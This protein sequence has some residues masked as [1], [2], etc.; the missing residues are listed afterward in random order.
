M[1][2]VQAGIAGTVTGFAAEDAQAVEFGEDLL[3]ISPEDS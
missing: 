3:Y 1:N 2:P